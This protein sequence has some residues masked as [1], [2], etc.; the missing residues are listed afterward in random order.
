[1]CWIKLTL[2]SYKNAK[3]KQTY[4]TIRTVPQYIPHHK[5]S[6]TIHTTPSR[7]FHNTY[8]TVRTVP[9]YIPHHQDS[10]IIHTTPSRQF[11]NTHHTIR[12]VQ[13]YIPHH[14]DSSTIHTTPSGQFNNRLF[15][16]SEEQSIQLENAVTWSN[17][18]LNVMNIYEEKY[19]KFLDTSDVV[20]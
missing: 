11:H 15:E 20:W 6:S 7:Q 17:S 10:S 13:Q 1:L 2:I 9:Q 4:H 14:Q 12:T 19:I 18:N 16:K 8:H 5:D 3:Q